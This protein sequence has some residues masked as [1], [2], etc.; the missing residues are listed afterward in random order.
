MSVS[1]LDENGD[2]T[3]GQGLAGYI[4]GSEEIQQ[5]LVT[6]IKSFKNDWF[7]DTDAYID[8]F[9]LLSN[10]NTEETTKAQLSKTVLDTKGIN[11]LNQL[12]FILNRENRTADIQLTYT[13]IY[14]ASTSVTVPV[15]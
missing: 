12:N 7:L 15:G 3:F 11:T 5:N 2:W 8:W 10:R 1:R 6:R 4:T 9:N 13:D 14:G